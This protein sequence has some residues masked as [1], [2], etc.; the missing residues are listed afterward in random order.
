[1]CEIVQIKRVR[2]GENL[3]FVHTHTSKNCQE[4]F[5]H[6]CKLIT[7]LINGYLTVLTSN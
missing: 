2:N 3:D 1:M 4:I 6:I 5:V 7:V